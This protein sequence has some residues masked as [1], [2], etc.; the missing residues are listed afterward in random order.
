VSEHDSIKTLAT[1]EEAETCWKYGESPYDRTAE[2]LINSGVINLDKPRGPTS[3]N[4][5]ATV[6]K[7]L[8]V[9][10]AGHTG[11]LVH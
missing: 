2:R 3:H 8:G 5:V 10:K 7:I 6:K 1:R 9:R 4:V 11:T